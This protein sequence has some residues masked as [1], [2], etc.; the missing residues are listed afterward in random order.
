[1]WNYLEVMEMYMLAMAIVGTEPVKPLPEAPESITSEP[2]DYVMFPYQ[3]SLDYLGRARAWVQATLRRCTP[4]Q[5]YEALKELDRAERQK[6]VDRF[7]T[8][9][10]ES[11]GKIFADVWKSNKED[12]KCK[13]LPLE[14]G[15]SAREKEL[16]AQ[17]RQLKERSAA[18]NSIRK[19]LQPPKED[20]KG[21]G[22]P[23]GGKGGGK[24]GTGGT[25]NPATVEK[26][27]NGK[28][29]CTEYNAGGCSRGAK[30]SKANPELHLCN[31]R[32]PG[33]TAACAGKHP[34]IGCNLCEQLS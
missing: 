21:K 28:R 7:R 1:M 10:K 14:S 3:F 27:M 18:A 20:R 15:R 33:T 16:E 9:E 17:V 34:S 2:F 25:G 26:M 13:H 23:K 4:N 12:W 6:W 32:K 19:G 30:C 8:H 22:K 5:A 24:R 29:L 31:G 11:I